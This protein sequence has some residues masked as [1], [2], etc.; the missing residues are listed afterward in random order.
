MERP[1]SNTVKPA[2][3]NQIPFS[4]PSAIAQDGEAVAPPSIDEASPIR[5]AQVGRPDR[6]CKEPIDEL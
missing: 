2:I 5:A 1:L 6:P 4:Q 3:V